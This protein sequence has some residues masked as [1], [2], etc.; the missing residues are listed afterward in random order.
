[1]EFSRFS[2]FCGFLRFVRFLRFVGFFRFWFSTSQPGTPFG[3]AAE[4]L[5]TELA[6]EFEMVAELI[7][8]H[9]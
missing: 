6:K 2:R 1:L 5:D 4:A 3:F 9:D 7:S 8:G